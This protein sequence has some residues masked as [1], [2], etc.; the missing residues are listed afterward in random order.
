MDI[1]EFIERQLAVWPEAA[2]RFE[3]LKMVESK[4]VGG[5]RVQF[6]PARAVST[7][8]K[9][10]A[11]S[12]AARPCF[13]CAKNRPKEQMAMDWE[14]LQILVN[15]FPIFPG[16]LTI[17][18]KEHQP[19]SMLG[20]TEQ[21]RR[22]SKALP[23][24]T[25]FYNGAKAGA[26]APDHFHFQAVPSEYMRIPKR[27]CTYELAPAEFSAEEIDPM[28]NMVC[29][30]GVVTVIPRPKHRPDCY[31][32]FL[33]SPAGIDLCGTL[34]S[35]RRED[36]DRLDAERVDSILKE[37]TFA[38]PPVY[39][40]LIT[41]EP[42]VTTRNGIHE[43]E[44]I[45]IGKDFHWER[46]QAQRFGGE[47][48][49]HDGQLINRLDIEEYLRSVI[50]SE[51]AATSSVELLK[52]HAVISRS[53]LL[54]QMRA[55]RAM[56]Y[57]GEPAAESPM[58]PGEI[59]QWFDSE[60]HAGFDV[61]SD[62][63][64]Q[65]YQGLGRITSANVDA[66]I[67]ATRGQVLSY[68]GRICD[69]RFSKCCGGRLEEFEACWQPMHHPYLIPVTDTYCANVPAEV[70]AQVLNNFDRDTTPD[71]Y[72][73][74]VRYTQAELSDLV[75]RRSGNDFGAVTD[76]IPIERGKSGRITRL[77][78]V[79]T[80]QTRII[81][82]ELIIR[83]WLSKSHL[84]S[85]NFEVE[86]SGNDFILH[87]AGWGHGVGLCQIGAANMAAQGQNYVDILAHY[88]PGAK[89][90]DANTC[91]GQNFDVNLHSL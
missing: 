30:D 58:E 1:K 71:Y 77:K 2:A 5:Y 51:M 16:H 80:K 79:G 74:S 17:S 67:E 21:M 25:V 47:M 66:A 50:S 19:Q 20:R 7:A 85:S 27:F 52:A 37:V 76:L 68:H 54:C 56:A 81:G 64:C 63:H 40:G 43:V 88:Y 14:D 39:V 24:Y 38:T 65:R 36:F 35:V 41:Y 90:C 46:R 69:A 12:I 3:A 78:V 87:G 26:S 49:K 73:W 72:R 32:D 44:G 6:N 53:W 70:L 8:A 57:K 82:K 55:T 48:L 11:A 83:K 23:G 33:V 59:R 22:L 42:K 60:N 9:V 84:Y 10:D 45:V 89:I 31:G 62:D 75:R 15:P 34:I 86:R 91:I 61:C 18:A 13:L 29:T 28:V 4:I